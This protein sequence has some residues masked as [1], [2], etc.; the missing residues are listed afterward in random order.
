MIESSSSDKVYQFHHHSNNMPQ[1]KYRFTQNL[2][3]DN[4]MKE[5]YHVWQHLP[6]F[7][8]NSLQRPTFLPVRFGEPS[9]VTFTN[10]SHDKFSRSKQAETLLNKSCPVMGIPWKEMLCSLKMAYLAYQAYRLGSDRCKKVF[11]SPFSFENTTFTAL[12]FSKG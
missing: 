1:S 3:V 6:H 7:V 12:V 8:L 5:S 2:L 9:V 11:R 10:L 4:T